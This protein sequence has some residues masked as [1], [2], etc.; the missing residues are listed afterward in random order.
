[1]KEKLRDL[2]YNMKLVLSKSAMQENEELLRNL[3]DELVA[4]MGNNGERYPLKP[5]DVETQLR[6]A[7][8]V[9]MTFDKA[10][11]MTNAL[12]Q[13]T[14]C[15]GDEVGRLIDAT[16]CHVVC[17]L[18]KLK[19]LHLTGDIK[20]FGVY[21]ADQSEE[22]K[23]DNFGLESV[24]KRLIRQGSNI[25]S[26]DLRVS[27]RA[28]PD[29][30][31]CLSKAI[32]NSSV[33]P[34]VTAAQRSM[35]SGNQR[36][37]LPIQKF[38]AALIQLTQNESKPSHSTSSVNWQEIHAAWELKNRIRSVSD[39][40]IMFICAYDLTAKMLS[41]HAMKN[42]GL[43]Q[44]ARIQVKKIDAIIGDEDEV[45]IVLLSKVS[46]W[47]WEFLLNAER[48]VVAWTRAKHGL[49][50]FGNFA[51]YAQKGTTKAIVKAF[52]QETPIVTLD[53]IGMMV[54]PCARRQDGLILDQHG[55][56][57]IARGSRELE[58]LNQSWL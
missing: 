52:A 50:V 56:P 58:Q 35:L 6:S 9:F 31:K 22:L 30:C 28:H 24:L 25:R 32:Y 34:G 21:D 46:P 37:N 18:P 29:I 33:Q 49:F 27:Y 1:M 7:D 54:G 51:L 48:A 5:A 12:G 36:L 20:Q 47:G 2:P 17:A 42:G 53:Y 8:I 55:R 11:L 14:H 15:L 39:A 10:A 40:S 4:G 16:L 23:S 57:P 13:F 26:Y 38:P 41:E 44:N 3:G 19:M 43:G 45:V